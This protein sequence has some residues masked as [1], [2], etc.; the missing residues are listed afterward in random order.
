VL[1]WL[2]LNRQGI[3]TARCIV[4]RLMRDLGL[5]GAR[6]GRAVR[7]TVP[8]TGGQRAP[9]LLGRDFTAPGPGPPPGRQLHLRGGLVRDRLRRFRGYVD[10]YNNTRLHTATGGIPP[11]EHEAAYYAQNQPRAAAGPNT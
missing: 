1:L 7:T 9:D 10:W 11:A 8:G 2:E 4:E 6:R 3:A 5:Q